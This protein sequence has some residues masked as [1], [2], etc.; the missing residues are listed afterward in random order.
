LW[1]FEANARQTLEEIFEEFDLASAGVPGAEQFILKYRE[2]N[3]RMWDAYRNGEIDKA[4]LRGDRYLHTLRHFG[5]ENRELADS[6]GEFYIR[7][8]PRKKQLFPHVHESLDYLAG[9]YRLHIITNGF[10]EVQHIK[11]DN[12]NLR[13]Y[14]FE[15]VTSDEAGVKKPDPGIFNFALD[16]ASAHHRDSLMIGD[17]FKVDLE[18]ARKVGMDQVYF[19]PEGKAYSG[20]VTY[21]IRSLNE[22]KELL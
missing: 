8:S 22:L 6:V 13:K 15:V 21:E 3:N 12:S 10:E 14:F 18:G 19:N 16:K 20:E 9:R 7:E 5:V 1:D 4:T 17:D 2:V 11:L